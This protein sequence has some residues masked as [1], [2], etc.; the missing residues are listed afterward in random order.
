MS[1]EAARPGPRPC[2]EPEG[3][4]A[5]RLGRAEPEGTVLAN[6]GRQGADPLSKRGPERP[7][8]PP[9]GGRAPRGPKQRRR[10]LR[11]GLQRR[12][13]SM[14]A[15]EPL[16]RH[17]GRREEAATCRTTRAEP[18]RGP[19]AAAGPP[20]TGPPKRLPASEYGQPG[21]EGACTPRRRGRRPRGPMTRHPRGVPRR[22]ATPRTH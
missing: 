14:P 10:T 2:P 17:A 11:Q 12:R 3:V 1:R 21:R 7:R 13:A 4:R 18:H 6:R 19:A 20:P 16:P 5:K 15:T 9:R 8:P 22:W